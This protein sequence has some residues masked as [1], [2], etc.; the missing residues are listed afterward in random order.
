MCWSPKS[1]GRICDRRR[2]SLFRLPG[3]ACPPMPIRT[4]L[5]GRDGM[6]LAAGSGQGGTRRV[7]PRHQFRTRRRQG[8]TSLIQ[9]DFAVC[10][11]GEYR[12]IRITRSLRRRQNH[13]AQRRLLGGDR[14]KDGAGGAVPCLGMALAQIHQPGQV[15]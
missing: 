11:H 12:R 13:V 7:G 8:G 3:R 10:E 4:C 9:P 15:A 2:R 5:Q 1:S 6:G 14:A